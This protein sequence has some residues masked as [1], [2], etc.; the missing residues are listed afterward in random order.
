ML[1]TEGYDKT[2]LGGVHLVDSDDELTDTEG[3][4]EQG[5]LAGLAGLGIAG[6]EL[7]YEVGVKE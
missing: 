5:V 1:Y 3:E 2:D 7:T 6:L 4:G